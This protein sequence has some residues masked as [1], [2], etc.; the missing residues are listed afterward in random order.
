MEPAVRPHQ[1]M[2]F[3]CKQSQGSLPGALS[4]SSLTLTAGSSLSTT[5]LQFWT[6]R[7][8]CVSAP[9]VSIF[10]LHLYTQAMNLAVQQTNSNVS[11]AV[12]QD[13]NQN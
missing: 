9:Q 8:M 12:K 3:C 10:R 6:V 5:I 13:E 1:T 7:Q 11:N 2:A 4:L